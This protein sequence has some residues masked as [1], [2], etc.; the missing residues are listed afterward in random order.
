MT[1]RKKAALARAPE[2]QVVITGVAALTPLGF[3]YRELK[4]GL[5]RSEARIGPLS[6]FSGVSGA[7]GL[8]GGEL[9]GFDPKLILGAKGLRNKDRNTLLVLAC[10]ELDLAREIEAINSPETVGLTVG[11]TFGSLASQVAFTETYLKEGFR[12][13]NAM[14]FPNM[15]INAPPSQ[16]NIWFDLA[17][18]STTISNGFTAGLDAITFSADQIRAGRATHVIAGGAD[19]LSLHLALAFERAGLASRRRRVAPLDQGRDGTL[20]GEGAAMVLLE[21]RETAARRGARVVAEVLG[22]GSSFDGTLDYAF[23]AEA[24]GAERAM[25]EALDEAGVEPGDV[26]F[27]AASANGSVDGDRMEAVAIERVFE[28][29]ASSLPIV[30]YKSYWG[31]CYSASGAM[32]VA[33]ALADLEDGVISATCGIEAPEAGLA[34]TRRALLDRAPSTV[35]VNSFGYT[36]Q[37]T[38]VVLRAVRP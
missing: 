27:I 2:Q 11:T 16:G 7:E 25:R 31:D 8:Y 32:Q 37:N 28:A 19:E 38:S 24:D 26:D 17:A 14:D 9:P 5:R 29:H 4:R 6:L 10:I 20:L 21:S 35:L 13:L 34:L 12:A 23:N 3:G 22:Y 30:A 1:E 15:V 36:G 18:S 33:A